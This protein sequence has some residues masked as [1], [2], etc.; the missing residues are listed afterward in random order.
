MGDAGVVS[1]LDIWTDEMARRWSERDLVVAMGMTKD[2]R[3]LPILFS[4]LDGRVTSLQEVAARS[5]GEI[6]DKGALPVLRK[7][8]EDANPA[9][10]NAVVDAI[11]RIEA[12]VRGG[13]KE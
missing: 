4:V 10:R 6:A 7:H 8:H 5:L 12:N 2:T 3:F 9:V 13:K 1:L 11:N